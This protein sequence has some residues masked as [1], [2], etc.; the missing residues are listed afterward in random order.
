MDMTWFKN[1]VARFQQEH[2]GA[3]LENS[4]IV[5]N[6]EELEVLAADSGF[7]P[8]DLGTPHIGEF[9]GY[10]VFKGQDLEEGYIV[11]CKDTSDLPEHPEHP[12]DIKRVLAV[13][14]GV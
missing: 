12:A 5:A 13:Y 14:E 3:N 2:G 10:K 7:N 6:S 11:I 9:D 4:S 8:T 1:S